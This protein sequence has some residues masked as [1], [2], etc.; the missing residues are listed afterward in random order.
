MEGGENLAVVGIVEEQHPDRPLLFMQWKRM[1]WPLMVDPLNLLGVA[2]VPITLLLDERG[3]VRATDLG[4]GDAGRVARMLLEPDAPVAPGSGRS[5]VPATHSSRP[6][7]LDRLR[8]AAARGDAPARL[9][10]ADALVLWGGPGRLDDAIDVYGRALALRPDDGPARFRLGVAHR[11]RYDFR[12]RR[13]E[14][15]R[16]AVEE[17]TRALEIE[18]NQYIWRRRLQQYGPRLDK[19]YSFYDWV[20]AAREEIR[21]RGETP[22]ALSVEPAGAELAH[23]AKVFEGTPDDGPEPDPRGRIERDTRGFV[24]AETVVVP[25]VVAPGGAARVHLALRPNA[26]IKAHWNNEVGETVL[27]IDPPEGWQVGA[28]RVTAPRP[29]APVSQEIRSLEFEVRSPARLDRGPATIPAYVLYYVCEDVKG[30]CLYRRQDLEIPVAIR[31]G[32]P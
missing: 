1:G 12:G 17:W 4:P 23:P 2:Y 20:S 31:A 21:S 14:D 16:H 11:M 27:W 7:D 25:P 32:A 3:V 8:A 22:R 10:Y 6:P 29:H 9:A 19:P 24:L 26:G 28:R 5:A 30:K 18:P 13:P 15:F